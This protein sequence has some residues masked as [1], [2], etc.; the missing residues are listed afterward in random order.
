MVPKVSRW[1][2]PSWRPRIALVSTE[3]GAQDL[4]LGFSMVSMVLMGEP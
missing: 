4:K 2:S 3:G 1:V